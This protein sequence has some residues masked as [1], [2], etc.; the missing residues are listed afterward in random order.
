MFNMERKRL[1]GD[2][3]AVSKNFKENH[4]DKGGFL[5][6]LFTLCGFNVWNWGQRLEV[7]V[8]QVLAQYQKKNFFFNN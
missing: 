5:Y 2:R 4:V 1:K 7:I 8:R 3:V 6:S